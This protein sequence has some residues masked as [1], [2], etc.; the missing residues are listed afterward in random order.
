MNKKRNALHNLISDF[1]WDEE[2][3]ALQDSIVEQALKRIKCNK[4]S[5]S[6]HLSTYFLL[7]TSN[8]GEIFYFESCFEEP[9]M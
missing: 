3:A 9:V 7:P 5:A 4:K 1:S 8:I 6:K 2:G